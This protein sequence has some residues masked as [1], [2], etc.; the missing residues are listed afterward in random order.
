MPSILIIN[1]QEMTNDKAIAD[2]LNKFFSSIGEK[3]GLSC[4][5][6]KSTI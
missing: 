4:T 5:K 3:L 1:E 6:T 2:Q